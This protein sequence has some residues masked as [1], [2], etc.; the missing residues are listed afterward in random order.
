LNGADEFNGIQ[1]L[2]ST[3]LNTIQHLPSMQAE[4]PGNVT[5]RTSGR[6]RLKMK[7]WP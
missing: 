3:Q 7:K 4:S 5:D 6:E 1:R 2:G